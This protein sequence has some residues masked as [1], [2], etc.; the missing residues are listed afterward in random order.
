[1]A[2]LPELNKWC[3]ELA[4]YLGGDMKRHHIRRWAMWTL[5]AYIEANHGKL[6]LPP[7]V[8]PA[9]PTGRRFGLS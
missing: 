2:T 6:I 1:M 5:S 4:A 8:P 3:D 7:V 9:P